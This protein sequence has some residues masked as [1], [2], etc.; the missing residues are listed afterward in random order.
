MFE[1]VKRYSVFANRTG[2]T[3]AEK[4]T[5]DDRPGL[6]LEPSDTTDKKNVVP[7]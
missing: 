7:E 6:S 3:P 5:I 2:S 1:L 4:V